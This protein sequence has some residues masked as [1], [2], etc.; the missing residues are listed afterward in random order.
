ME[1]IILVL[2][3]GCLVVLVIFKLIAM[4]NMKI[5]IRNIKKIQA[6]DGDNIKRVTEEIDECNSG[7]NCNAGLYSQLN[8]KVE[9]LLVPR[10]E[11]KD[12]I[13]AAKSEIVIYIGDCNE[14]LKNN[15]TN[16]ILKEIS[17]KLDPFKKPEASEI[18]LE[19]GEFVAPEDSL[20]RES[21]NIPLE[22]LGKKI[23]SQKSD[24]K[25]K[26]ELE[27]LL[28]AKQRKRRY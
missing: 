14:S 15:I 10:Y 22:S 7:A 27:E 26:E 5:D 20:G 28:K 3:F 13:E 11:M 21:K 24:T 23:I 18:L 2:I 19:I 4:K 9:T 16:R 25:Y 6:S 12:A 8:A 17:E 1:I